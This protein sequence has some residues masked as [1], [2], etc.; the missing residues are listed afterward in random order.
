MVAQAGAGPDPVPYTE[1]T[2][3]RL[4]DA[5]SYALMPEARAAATQIAEKMKTESGVKAAVVHFHS[6]LPLQSLR[7]DLFPEFPAVWS[8]KGRHHS[9]LL[10]R[11]AERIVSRAR[12]LDDRKLTLLVPRTLR[13][14][15]AY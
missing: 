4:A 9:V 10:S 12:K 11:Q 1:L 5:I 6:M 15:I 8:Y 3:R 14:P 2:S 13:S 7:C